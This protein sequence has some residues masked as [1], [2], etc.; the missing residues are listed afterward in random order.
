MA[1][2]LL[3]DRQTNAD[4]GVIMGLTVISALPA[5]PGNALAGIAPASGLADDITSGAFAALLNSG[6]L[7]Q[8]ELTAKPDGLLPSGQRDDKTASDNIVDTSLLASLFNQPA[9]A[10]LMPKSVAAAASA[11][12]GDDFDSSIND[13]GK[14]ITGGRIDR[15]PDL[16]FVNTSPQKTDNPF[17]RTPDA[18]QSAV[19]TSRPS[20]ANIAAEANG[21]EAPAAFASQVAAASAAAT[22]SASHAAN[23]ASQ[24][25][26][27]PLHAPVWPQQ[28][29]DK[30]VWLARD[31][32]Q[33]AQ[34]N[35]NPPQLGPVQVT[36]NLSGDQA[37]LVFASRHAEVRQAIESA[38]PQLKEMLAAAGINLGQA[39]VGPNLQQQRGDTAFDQANQARFADE[40]AILPASEKG[41]SAAGATVVQRG[42]GLVDLFA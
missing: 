35:I 12:T 2:S 40:N 13:D 14:A 5:V 1:H 15:Q 25:I 37:S 36:V 34:L 4:Q 16:P 17:A 33:T 41:A 29:G 8:I 26:A 3:I 18:A 30:V 31:G 23:P 11:A 20:A 9:S 42:R 21:N 28:F 24:S 10:D 38:M 32:Q 22:A 27:A 7:G 6:L 39:N 19:A